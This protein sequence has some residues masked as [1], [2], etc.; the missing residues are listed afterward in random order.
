MYGSVYGGLYKVK[1]SS[2]KMLIWLGTLTIKQTIS[3]SIFWEYGDKDAVG[4]VDS[5]E[6]DSLFNTNEDL[7]SK[8]Y[9][10]YGYSRFI[11]E[12]SS[13]VSVQE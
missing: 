1:L 7:L 10:S 2:K 12:T 5:K 9:C 8:D 6:D 3:R 4:G 11:K 13:R